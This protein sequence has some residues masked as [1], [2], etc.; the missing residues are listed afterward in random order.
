M[1]QQLTAFVREH[2]RSVWALEVLLILRRDPGR[3]WQVEELVRELR[4][5]NLL[6]NANL[7]AFER[8]GLVI[9]DEAG[10]YRYSPANPLLD[11]LCGK[12]EA[13]YKERPVATINL[14]S[15]P[16]GDAVQSLADAFRLRGKPK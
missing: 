16:D 8:G 3:Q 10:G 1:V 7:E 2:V 11:E 6:V 14:I 4:A 12:L 9:R 13:A 15:R 5:S